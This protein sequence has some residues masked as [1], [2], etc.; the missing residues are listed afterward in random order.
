MASHLSGVQWA[1]WDSRPF[2]CHRQLPLSASRITRL[3]H[4]PR[5]RTTAHLRSL[6]RSLPYRCRACWPSNAGQALYTAASAVSVGT[7]DLLHSMLLSPRRISHTHGTSPPV[8]EQSPGS[9]DLARP[10]VLPHR[11]IAQ[12]SLRRPTRDECVMHDM[13]LSTP[14]ASK[15]H[16][17]GRS[18]SSILASVVFSFLL[19][20]HF[21]LIPHCVLFVFSERIS[22]VTTIGQT[23]S[24]PFWVQHLLE[25]LHVGHFPWSERRVQ[26]ASRLRVRHTRLVFCLMSFIWLGA[27]LVLSM[28]CLLMMRYEH[29]HAHL[30]LTLSVSRTC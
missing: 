30:R 4:T 6:H 24:F 18:L 23:A 16:S 20:V 22:F 21:S 19:I 14:A 10:P 2:S 12:S 5:V 9:V 28:A 25:A 13:M 8:S 3:A 11:L 26:T 27:H 17:M 15:Q 1:P 29:L 7:Q